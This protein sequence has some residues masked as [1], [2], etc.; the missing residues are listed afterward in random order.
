MQ[1]PFSS[2]FIYL[3]EAA[4]PELKKDYAIVIE[5]FIKQR[6]K[7]VKNR[8]D[9]YI[10]PTFPK[11]LYVL[12]DDNI[13]QDQPYFY[14]TRLAAEC[15]AKRMVPDYIS[16]KK[17]KELKEGN[18]FGCINKPVHHGG[19]TITKNLLKRGKLIRMIA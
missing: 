9:I 13:K 17:M 16:E 14:L 1:S 18:V 3:N 12:E 4:T 10:P 19:D 6:I 11:I 15:T 8:K 5:A 7:G 2:I